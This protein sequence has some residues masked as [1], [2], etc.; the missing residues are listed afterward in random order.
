MAGPS[1]SSIDEVVL[2]QEGMDLYHYSC[3]AQ[4]MYDN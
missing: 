1:E 4:G 2:N 3:G